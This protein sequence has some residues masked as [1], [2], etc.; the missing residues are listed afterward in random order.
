MNDP[1]DDKQRFNRGEECSLAA[2]TFH[3]L[4]LIKIV[5]YVDIAFFY[6]K[7]NILRRWSNRQTH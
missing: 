7:A 5:F 1:L 3:A 4:E 6:R 2:T